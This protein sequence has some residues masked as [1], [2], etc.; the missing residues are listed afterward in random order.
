MRR[1][2]T[3]SI[4]VFLFFF[5]IFLFLKD[6]LLQVDT[7]ISY[8]VKGIWKQDLLW[9]YKPITEFGDVYIL[10]I[11][12]LITGFFLYKKDKPKFLPF[13]FLMGTSAFLVLL[14]KNV[15]ARPRPDIMGFY[16]FDGYSFPSGHSVMS[17][18]FY[19]YIASLILEKGKTKNKYAFACF[20]IILLIS[21]G[22][23]RIY[24]GAHYLSDVLT[25]FILGSL[26][27]NIALLWQE[28]RKKV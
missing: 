16:V 2:I 17:S 28:K 5:M 6:N 24:L 4:L 8:W 26:L 23:S 25:G 13:L 11:L 10:P 9:F 7:Q 20:P 22:F 14:L 3:I 15:F 19:L 18:V 27:L 12:I 1:K 21:I